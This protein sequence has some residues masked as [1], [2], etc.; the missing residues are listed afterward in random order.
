MHVSPP[1]TPACHSCKDCV[2]MHACASL[3]LMQ[4]LH[5]RVH[6]TTTHTKAA[7]T[8]GPGHHSCKGCERTHTEP[9]LVHQTATHARA[10]CSCVCA[11]SLLTQPS[12]LSPLSWA[13]KP[14]IYSHLKVFLTSIF[15]PNIKG[16]KKV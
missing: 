8:H 9:P 13:V 4:G 10:V 11:G 16:P 1:L 5:V 7:C 15:H 14:G 6:Q 12:S 2:R 3:P